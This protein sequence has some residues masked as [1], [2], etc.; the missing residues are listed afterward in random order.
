MRKVYAPIIVFAYNRP[1]HL[2]NLLSSLERNPESRF[3]TVH[4]FVDGPK[5]NHDE[6]QVKKTRSVASTVWPYGEIHLHF[7]ST[8]LGLGNSIRR[9]ISEVISN[10]GSA[11]VLEDDLVLSESF[12]KF[13]NSGIDRY[14][15]DPRVSGIHGFSFA[16]GDDLKEPYF[17]RGADCLGWATW[18]DRWE[19]IVWEPTQLLSQIETAG[20]IDEFNLRGAH[21]YSSALHHEKRHGFRSWAIYWH[22]SMFAQGRLMLF[23]NHSLVRYAGA[24]G[25]GTHLI[26]RADFWDTDLS[27][28]STWNL[29]N[30]IKESQEAKDLYIAYHKRFFPR[31]SLPRRIVR[32]IIFLIRNGFLRT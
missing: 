24:D 30:D 32:K 29:P 7:A 13:M 28:E 14:Q 10:S 5:G 16:L 3:S 8:N 21:S 15:D 31:L 25:S 19:S 23:P 27:H 26:G 6:D 9:G 17:L 20:E 4:I 1:G 2:L 12:L 11:I 18:K 22:S